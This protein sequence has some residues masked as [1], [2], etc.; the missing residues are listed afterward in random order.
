LYKRYSTQ[1]NVAL[2]ALFSSD[3]LECTCPTHCLYTAWRSF[4]LL[5][6]FPSLLPVV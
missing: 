3:P 5:K 1:N 6:W 4:V 2:I